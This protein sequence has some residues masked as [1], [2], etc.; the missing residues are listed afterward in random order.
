MNKQYK[1]FGITPSEPTLIMRISIEQELQEDKPRI[2]EVLIKVVQIQATSEVIETKNGPEANTR[3]DYLTGNGIFYN[4]ELSGVS[5]A[6]DED[7]STCIKLN[8]ITTKGSNTASLI[9]PNKS[10]SAEQVQHKRHLDLIVDHLA[11][12][13]Y[14][15]EIDKDVIVNFL[16]E[17]FSKMAGNATYLDSLE[18]SK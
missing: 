3:I 16:L 7:E 14:S 6:T 11:P 4:D 1:L 8:F 12:E 10:Y 5:T 18:A 9:I 17:V 13:R 2:E 15:V